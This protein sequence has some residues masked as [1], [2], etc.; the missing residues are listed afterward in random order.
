MKVIE[1]NNTEF[2]DKINNSKGKVLVDCFATW[3]GPCEMLSPV[4]DDLAKEM[5]NVTFYKLDVDSAEDIA[6]KY[7]IMSIPTILLFKDGNLIKKDVGFKPKEELNTLREI[8]TKH[9]AVPFILDGEPQGD[10]LWVL[11]SIDENYEII[12]NHGTVIAVE[13]SLKLKEYIEV[14]ENG[15]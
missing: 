9:E 5:D 6:Q 13:V 10:G 15:D 12:D 1:I 3:C 4:I 7:G 2:D 14:E 8:L 11:E